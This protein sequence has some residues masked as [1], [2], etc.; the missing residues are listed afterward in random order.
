MFL[1]Y[2]VDASAKS[3]LKYFATSKIY[4]TLLVY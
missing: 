4:L 1:S 3:K 2:N